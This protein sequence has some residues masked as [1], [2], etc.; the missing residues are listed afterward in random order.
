MT[1]WQVFIALAIGVPILLFAL[2][3]L[4]P[5]EGCRLRR[6]RIA[7]AVAAIK[8]KNNQAD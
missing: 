2:A 5:C 4:L 6:E 1:Q 3:A 8:H 7:R